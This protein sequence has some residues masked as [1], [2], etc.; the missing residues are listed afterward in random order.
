MRA[1]FG[2]FSAVFAMIRFALIAY[3]SLATFFGPSL[4]CC[5]AQQLISKAETPATCCSRLANALSSGESPVGTRANEQPV[6]DG[7]SHKHG[8]DGQDCPCGKGQSNLVATATA[9]GAAADHGK[10]LPHSSVLADALLSVSADRDEANRSL[11]LWR[12]PAALS[13]RDLLRVY[14]I[15]RS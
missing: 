4:C 3:L 9:V 5:H 13:G 6:S 14:Q 1:R 2:L 15:L 11:L 12:R 8:H 7:H 10:S